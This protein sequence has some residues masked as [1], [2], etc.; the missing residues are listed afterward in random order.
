MI[1]RP[2]GQSDDAVDYVAAF[3]I[4]SGIIDGWFLPNSLTRP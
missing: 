4:H 1:L 3:A 2:F